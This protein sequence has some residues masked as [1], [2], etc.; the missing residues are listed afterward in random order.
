[1][2]IYISGP[3]TDKTTG[4]VSKA[5]IEAFYKM[6]Q[7]L[8][9]AGNTHIVNP[10]KVWACRFPWIYKI[11]GYRLTLWYDLLLLRSCDAI[12]LLSGWQNS[13]G[14]FAEFSLACRLRL[15]ILKSSK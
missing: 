15:T 2:R 14:A 13:N 3:M 11:V 7:R 4:K 12:C 8:R 5:N 1:M 6:E 10:A 9:D